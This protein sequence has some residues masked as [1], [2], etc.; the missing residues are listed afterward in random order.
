MMIRRQ[1][2]DVGTKPKAL[3]LL[4]LPGAKSNLAS[5]FRVRR[6]LLKPIRDLVLA[7]SALS[8]D[9]ADLL[10]ELLWV[11]KGNGEIKP[12][13]DGFVT[14]KQLEGSLLN[15]QPHV[16]RRIKEM[17]NEEWVESEETKVGHGF[18]ANSHRTRITG[19]GL[20]I[21]EP[22]WAKYQKLA[23]E[24]FQ[25]ISGKDR[26]THLRVNENIR[27][28]IHP[29]RH[30]VSTRSGNPADNLISILKARRELISPIKKVVLQGSH[31][32]LENADILMCLYGAKE[33]PWSEPN[34]DKEGFVLFGTL[35][36]SLVHCQALSQILLSRR[37]RALQSRG[38]VE[39]RR[40]QHDRKYLVGR[41]AV[42]VT[43]LGA[44]AVAPVCTKY[45]ELSEMLL[46]GISQRD[47]LVHWNVSEEIL[48]KLHPAW[49]RLG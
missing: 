35:Q 29:Y 41:D 18:H 19:R 3:L 47:R 30:F 25:E 23:D 15:S 46:R 27:R 9:R 49:A 42:G 32:T 1:T 48:K 12:D 31:L 20:K 24:I 10:L 6:D 26:Q 45:E 11:R 40:A 4:L 2:T 8:V 43:N 21:I 13:A 44:K 33:L 37:I 5:I 39:I 36:E 7:D 38:W 34:A 28:A 17:A 14:F 22:V 16:S